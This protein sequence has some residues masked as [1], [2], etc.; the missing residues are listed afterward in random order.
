[1]RPD[2]QDFQGTAVTVEL[3]RR[4]EVPEMLIVVNKVPAGGDER[5]AAATESKRRIGAEVAAMLPLSRRNG[6]HGQRRHVRQS[7][8]PTIPFSQ[9]IAAAR[10]DDLTSPTAVEPRRSKCPHGGAQQA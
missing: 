5:A 1:M 9:A 7:L 4:L 6:P 10:F 8:I 3:A 2:K